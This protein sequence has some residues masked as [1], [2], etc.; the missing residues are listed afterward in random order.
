MANVILLL[1]DILLGIKFSKLKSIFF[2]I[3]SKDSGRFFMIIITYF[4]SYYFLF[5]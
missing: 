4:L 3:A 1:S 2:E 5:A